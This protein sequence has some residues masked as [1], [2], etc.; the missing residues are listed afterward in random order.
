MVYFSSQPEDLTPIERGVVFV[1]E[2]VEQ[3]DFAIDIID[4][5]TSN[6]V[7]SKIIKGVESAQVDL[8][9]GIAT[10]TGNAKAKEVIKSIESLGFEA[11]VK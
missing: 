8:A 7:A 3:S 4:Y 6:V 9:S 11:T 2:S 1:V 10:Y 5:N